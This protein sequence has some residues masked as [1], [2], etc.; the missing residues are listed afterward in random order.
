MTTFFRGIT[1]IILCLFHGIFLYKIP[2]PTLLLTNESLRTKASWIFQLHYSAEDGIDIEEFQLFCAGTENSRNFVPNHSAEEKKAKNCVPWNKKLKQTLGTP[3]QTI[4]RKR[5]NAEFRN[6][7]RSKL[8]EL[9]SEAYLG[10][11]YAVNSVCWSKIF[12]ITNSFH[13]VLFQASELTLPWN[14]E[15]LF[16]G[17]TEIILSLFRGIFSERNSV[18]NPTSIQWESQNLRGRVKATSNQCRW[19]CSQS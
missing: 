3:F 15:C 10:Q 1:E 8:S 17:I 19:L 2:L 18:A 14:S 13:G 4:P 5:T 9:R 7:K 6:K 12:C 11:K 16:R